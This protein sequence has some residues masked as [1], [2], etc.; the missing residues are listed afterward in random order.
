MPTTTSQL[1]IHQP[2]SSGSA[3]TTTQPRTR[4]RRASWAHPVSFHQHA[5]VLNNGSP[6]LVNLDT[7]SPV[8]PQPQ[9]SLQVS[10]PQPP[11]QS[12]PTPLQLQQALL[13]HMTHLIHQHQSA[14]SSAARIQ[15]QQ[16]AQ[17]IESTSNTPST[18]G[19]HLFPVYVWP[20][21]VLFRGALNLIAVFTSLDFEFN[22][23]QI[24]TTHHSVTMPGSWKSSSSDSPSSSAS[25]N[26]SRTDETVPT[27][28]LLLVHHHHFN[29]TQKCANLIKLE[30]LSSHIR[31]LRGIL[32]AERSARTQI[33]QVHAKTMMVVEDQKDVIYKLEET[34]ENLKDEVETLRARLVEALFDK[35]SVGFTN[36][37][38]VDSGFYSNKSDEEDHV[39]IS[40][41]VTAPTFQLRLPDDILDTIS[42]DGCGCM[43]DEDDDEE[44][45]DW[46]TDDD[47]DE[48]EDTN[49]VTSIFQQI[50]ISP[51]PK[52]SAL[53]S[54]A[55]PLTRSPSPPNKHFQ[56]PEQLLTLASTA[57]LHPP[58]SPRQPR[59]NHPVNTNPLRKNR[60][61]S[62][63]TYI[64]PKRKQNPS[65]Q[66]LAAQSRALDDAH[67]AWKPA[68]GM[69]VYVLVDLEV[70]GA[71][72]VVCWWRR[73][74]RSG[75]GGRVFEGCVG[76]MDRLCKTLEE[77]CSSEEEE[78]DDSGEE[79]EDDEEDEGED[80]FD[81][82]KCFEEVEALQRD[83]G[84]CGVDEV[85]VGGCNER[86]VSFNI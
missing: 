36:S 19:L 48:A 38:R 55:E 78:S 70:V 27:S 49:P 83:R 80:G 4:Q 86:R 73:E 42:D 10:I 84:Y 66:D 3:T 65:P 81:E 21:I 28:E 25:T 51:N 45:I 13:S 76:F 14:S 62:P 40:P 46:D 41:T 23:I 68:F 5:L 39:K 60:T 35:S 64:T 20:F 77:V 43:S 33:S 75:E 30:S 2:Y 82:G 72:D 9:P 24:T 79:E 29:S 53:S 54:P 12:Q 1:R 63:L 22:F 44:E 58:N 11:S 52:S 59:N 7:S 15:T 17:V 61:H 67:V 56:T 6:G 71:A 57:L 47:D 50:P 37:E 74:K 32:E 69:L 85:V 31:H 18:A 26:N 8:S 16:Q 34:V